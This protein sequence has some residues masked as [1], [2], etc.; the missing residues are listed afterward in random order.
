MPCDIEGGGW[1][2]ENFVCGVKGVAEDGLAVGNASVH[3][4]MHA[5]MRTCVHS[6]MCAYLHLY[7]NN[8][9]DASVAEL[10]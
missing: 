4:C 7:V 8:N 9:G 1:S 5:C 3:A 10:K 2:A 6:I